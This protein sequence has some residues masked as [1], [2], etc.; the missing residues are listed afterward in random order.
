MVSVAVANRGFQY[1]CCVLSTIFRVQILRHPWSFVERHEY[2][3]EEMG[4]SE[5]SAM[6]LFELCNGSLSKYLSLGGLFWCMVSSVCQHLIISCCLRSAV[7]EDCRLLVCRWK[8]LNRVLGPSFGRV[9]AS[10]LVQVVRCPNRRRPWMLSVSQCHWL[11]ISC[12]Q[13]CR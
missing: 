7:M 6:Q 11:P 2:W 5:A 8:R 4:V 3:D 10:G 9:G 12:L 13:L 1:V